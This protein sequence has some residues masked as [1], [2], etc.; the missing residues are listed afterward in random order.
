MFDKSLTVHDFLLTL[1]Y[2]CDCRFNWHYT[3]PLLSGSYN[4]INAHKTVLSFNFGTIWVFE[5]KSTM[6]GCR[7]S[8][9]SKFDL[10][11]RP[12]N[13]V[14]NGNSPLKNSI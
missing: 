9:A 8:M 14:S 5:N 4:V 13:H 6:N 2:T 12:H 1:K 7:Y 11:K 10:Y 3:I